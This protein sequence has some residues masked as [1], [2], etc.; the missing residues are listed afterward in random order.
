[1]PAIA[2]DEA[3]ARL[4]T[5][6]QDA[7]A[8]DL[9]EI[10][11]EL[12]PGEPASEQAADEDVSPLMQQVADHLRRGRRGLEVEEIIDLWNVVFPRDRNVFYD[13]EN[14]TVHYNEGS[15][16]ARLAE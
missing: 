4:T 2:K 14:G 7:R 12:F 16:P 3:V 13:D 9:R 1:M 11:Q 5:A 15:E 10:Y 8:D 6:V